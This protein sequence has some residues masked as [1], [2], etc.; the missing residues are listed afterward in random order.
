MIKK[1]FT[2]LPFNLKILFPILIVLLFSLTIGGYLIS[3]FVKK[4]MTA[5]YMDSVQTLSHSIQDGVKGS[6]ERG[7]MQN[8]KKLLSDQKKIKGILDVSLYDLHEIGRAH[9]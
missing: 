2:N 6:L 1:A 8:F 7:Q 3:N 4:Q 9:V 5:T